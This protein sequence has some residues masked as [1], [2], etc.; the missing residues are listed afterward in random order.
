MLT[1]PA[2]IMRSAWRGEA[3]N[4]SAPKREMSNRGPTIAIIS[5]AQQASPKPSGQ[6]AFTRDWFTAQFTMPP[7][8]V[9]STPCSTSSRIAS[10]GV[11]GPPGVAG[12][13]GPGSTRNGFSI[14]G[15]SFGV[16]VTGSVPLECP[17][18]QQVDVAHEQD[19]DEQRHLDQ[20][21]QP[22]LAECDR[23][24]VEEHGLDVEQDEQH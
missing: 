22:Q 23:P 7:T 2:T 8:V 4:T 13:G 20:A 24:R 5:I 12:A 15:G 3:R 9:K 1:R 10:S 14:F 18:L 11:A 6:I 16:S 21:I 17:L 19:D